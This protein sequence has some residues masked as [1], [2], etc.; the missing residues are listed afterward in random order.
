MADSIFSSA[1]WFDLYLFLA[2][3]GLSFAMKMHKQLCPGEGRDLAWC[4]SLKGIISSWQ[5]SGF[6]FKWFLEADRT[7]Y[8]C[9]L[10]FSPS[11]TKDWHKPDYS[12]CSLDVIK[13]S[14]VGK[15]VSAHGILILIVRPLPQELI[16]P[17]LWSLWIWRRSFPR[18]F[19]ESRCL[20]FGLTTP[21][22]HVGQKGFRVHESMWSGPSPQWW[23]FACQEHLSRCLW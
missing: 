4:S 8:E 3:E 5:G 14:A 22:Y 16:Y 6:S 2:H 10:T 11:W 20:R 13:P 17:Y 9:G 12:W 1:I 18:V 19:W 21:H 23:L 15:N 7:S